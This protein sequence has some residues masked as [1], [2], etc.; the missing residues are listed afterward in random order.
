MNGI[1]SEKSHNYCCVRLGAP[2]PH[3]RVRKSLAYARRCTECD[4][5]HLRHDGVVQST[6]IASVI[7]KLYSRWR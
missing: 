1:Y 2:A 6:S 4:S 7:F 3:H 5:P